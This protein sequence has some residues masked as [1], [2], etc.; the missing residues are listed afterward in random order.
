MRAAWLG[1]ASRTT[2]LTAASFSGVATGRGHR[3]HAHRAPSVTGIGMDRSDVL[4]GALAA[5]EP[6]GLRH[7]VAASHRQP[8]R[9]E[10]CTRRPATPRSRRARRS[11]RRPRRRSRG[12]ARSGRRDGRSAGPPAQTGSLSQVIEL[13]FEKQHHF[14]CIPLRLR[15]DA[16]GRSPT[17]LRRR[18]RAAPD[19]RR[20]VPRPGPA[21]RGRSG[22]RSSR[23]TSRRP[24]GEG[25]AA[26]T[27][28]PPHSRYEAREA[29]QALGQAS[30]VAELVAK[31]EGRDGTDRGSRRARCA[32]PR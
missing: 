7:R 24:R 25:R 17:P 11:S 8:V 28:R 5:R 3:E 6:A 16:D 18:L 19:S 30:L 12:V 31:R 9:P 29:F 4:E 10:T 27:G 32:A 23:A 14:R 13:L 2:F 20:S 1:V 22:R 26:S 15:S 21:H